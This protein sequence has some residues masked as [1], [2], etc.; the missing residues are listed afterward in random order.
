MAK[1]AFIKCTQAQYDAELDNNLIDNNTA[2]W[3]IDSG[4]IYL[5]T[6]SMSGI[7]IPT[8][9]LEWDDS[10]PNIYAKNFDIL[11]S[12]DDGAYG[13]YHLLLAFRNST[14]PNQATYL[15]CCY[16]YRY[17]NLSGIR[18]YF[19]GIN[20]STGQFTVYVISMSPFG[21]TYSKYSYTYPETTFNAQSTAAPASSAVATYITTQIAGK[22]NTLTA[23]SGID[24]TSDT[25]SLKTATANDL[26]G[27]KVGS[28]LDIDANGVLSVSDTG[29]ISLGVMTT[30]I[31]Q[32]VSP[33]DQYGGYPGI[34]YRV[35]N[36][37]HIYI[38]GVVKIV[39]SALANKAISSATNNAV[40]ANLNPIP[41]EYRPKFNIPNGQG[42]TDTRGFNVYVS[43][44]SQKRDNPINW[45]LDNGSG[46]I[47]CE[48]F[49]GLTGAQ[50]ADWAVLD[51]DYFI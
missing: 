21:S 18:I 7:E 51:F 37:N 34:A 23:G 17:A 10:D 11:E 48:G 41:A 8:Y 1:V 16:E 5:G 24:I 25:I 30:S 50:S 46:Y 4:K 36:N 40:V 15:P 32:C 35:I 28:G 33:Y 20:A 27:V 31:V 6:N 14:Y 45:V 9:I 29:W 49:T 2:Y 3:C 39:N 38:R 22:Q 43:N 47:L 13:Q 42:G 12:I 44:R 19:C 26:G